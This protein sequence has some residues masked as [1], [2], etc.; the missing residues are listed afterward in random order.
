LPE[1]TN[2]RPAKYA[3]LRVKSCHDILPTITF[4]VLYDFFVISHDRVQ[5]LFSIRGTKRITPFSA[6]MRLW[7]HTADEIASALL[8][9]FVTMAKKGRRPLAAL[10][11]GAEV[12]SNAADRAFQQGNKD[13]AEKRRKDRQAA[14]GEPN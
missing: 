13:R 8:N 12:L 9:A 5:V 7:R 2:F 14:A 4:G 6:R 1:P 10:K 11:A 3:V